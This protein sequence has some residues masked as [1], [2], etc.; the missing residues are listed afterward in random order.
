MKIPN[1][2]KIGG[3]NI[4]IIQKEFGDVDGESD[5]FNDSITINKKLT[6]TQK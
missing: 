6:K 1:K 4:K 2:L 3:H 5:T